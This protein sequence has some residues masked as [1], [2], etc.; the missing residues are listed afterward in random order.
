MV[1]KILAVEDSPSVR[2]LIKMTLL[3][4]DYAVV[5]AKNGAEGM[6]QV[7][8]GGIDLVITD[9]NMPVMGGMEFI[10]AFRAHPHGSGVPVLVLTTEFSDELK[11][12]ARAAGATGWLSK[13]FQQ[14]QLIDAVRK[15]IGA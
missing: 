5:D 1:T 14:N 3:D 9:V 7:E 2:Q 8:K 15:V 12:E 4:Y 6:E 10:R 13:P 11:A